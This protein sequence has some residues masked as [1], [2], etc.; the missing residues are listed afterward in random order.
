MGIFLPR[1]SFRAHWLITVLN[2]ELSLVLLYCLVYA[3]N[4]KSGIRNLIYED[5]YRNCGARWWLGVSW[6]L[7]IRISLSGQQGPAWQPRDG[8]AECELQNHHPGPTGLQRFLQYPEMYLLSSFNHVWLHS[9]LFS[10]SSRSQCLFLKNDSWTNQAVS[11]CQYEKD[12]V[13]SSLFNYK[14]LE[15]MD[16]TISLQHAQAQVK[17]NPGFLY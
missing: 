9:V 15:I 11:K 13:I 5:I 17:N 3:P 10:F 16:K 4:V 8:I 7:L 12:F 2:T 14:H 6:Q 1:L